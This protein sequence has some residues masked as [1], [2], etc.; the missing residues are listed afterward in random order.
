MSEQQQWTRTRTTPPQ[1]LPE[2]PLWWAGVAAAKAGL[3]LSPKAPP[4]WVEGWIAA[5]CHLPLAPTLS[6]TL[7]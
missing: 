2:N 4:A 3:P 6:V 7:H 1:F 5:H